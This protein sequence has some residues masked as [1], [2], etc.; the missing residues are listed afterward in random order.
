MK[1]VV[2]AFN[3]EKALAELLKQSTRV[4]AGSCPPSVFPPVTCVTAGAGDWGPWCHHHTPSCLEGLHRALFR[5]GTSTHILRGWSLGTH[6]RAFHNM[7]PWHRAAP[8]SH[9]LLVSAG[10]VVCQ[11][12]VCGEMIVSKNGS[13][14]TTRL[15]AAAEVPV[16]LTPAARP[17]QGDTLATMFLRI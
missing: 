13:K 5:G 3:Q 14:K 11:S 7:D 12:S 6:C 9:R 1:A 8:C 16:W 2:A 4:Y 17:R 10:F 15:P